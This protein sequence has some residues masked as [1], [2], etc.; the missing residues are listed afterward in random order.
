MLSC[1]IM[2]R[3]TVFLPWN[4]IGGFSACIANLNEATCNEIIMIIWQSCSFNLSHETLL[5]NIK[6]NENEVDITL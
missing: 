4:I 2:T 1:Q 5:N 3:V 6:V